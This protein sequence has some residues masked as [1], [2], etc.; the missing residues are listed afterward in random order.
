MNN[1][2][3][4]YWWMVVLVCVSALILQRTDALAYVTDPKV[5]VGYVCIE[6]LSVR[7]FGDDGGGSSDSLTAWNWDRCIPPGIPEG[8]P[9]KFVLSTVTEDGESGVVAVDLKGSPR[10]AVDQVKSFMEAKDFLLT[11]PSAMAWNKDQSLPSAELII[12]DHRVHLVGTAQ[13]VGVSRV[14]IITTKE[15]KKKGSL[16]WE[17]NG[18]LR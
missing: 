8:L 2:T 15:N 4:I 9:G 13:E 16:P 3:K 1:K 11:G 14:T 12:D 7:L 10:K 6:G 18:L 5:R 17:R